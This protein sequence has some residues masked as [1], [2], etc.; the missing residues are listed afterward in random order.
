MVGN[1]LDKMKELDPV[2]RE[3]LDRYQRSMRL[4]NLK[5]TTIDNRLW[6]IYAYLKFI[7]L[8]DALASTAT[9]VEEFYL[10]RK[11]TKSPIT[12]QGDHLAVRLFLTYLM[13]GRENDLFTFKPQKVTYTLP[14]HQLIT[15][16]DMKQIVGGCDTLRDRALYMLIWDS[17]ARLNEIANLNL[18]NVHFKKNSKGAEIIVD[19]K[20]GLR[21]I[22]LTDSI[23]DVQEWINK[24]P[25]KEDGDAPLFVTYRGRGTAIHRLSP[26]TIQT[27]LKS[28]KKKLGISKRIWPHGVRHSRLTNLT[29]PNRGR[30]GLCEMELRHFAGWSERSSMPATYI[31]LSA[32]DLEQKIHARAG[33]IE[34]VD[35]EE[36]VGLEPQLCP[37]CGRVNAFDDVYCGGCSQL[38]DTRA[39]ENLRE[40]VD[41]IE[42]L[43]IYQRAVARAAEQIRE[44]LAQE[45]ARARTPP[46]S[47]AGT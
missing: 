33:M 25:L 10:E 45:L 2:N 30:P 8:K 13:P 11:A 47:S 24:H 17:G 42:D 41:R 19:G 29:K 34:D 31:H 5:D 35:S 3:H 16:Q 12:T 14:V 39:D 43:P 40:T 9:D 46:P 22:P 1:V 18:N 37:R 36:D 23:K 21:T 6:R 27:K 7:K 26:R 32:H 4:R 15:K 20:T 38:L 44:E 28:L